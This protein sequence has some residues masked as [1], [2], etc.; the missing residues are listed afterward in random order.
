MD[1]YNLVLTDV[2]PIDRR[3]SGNSLRLF[4]RQRFFDSF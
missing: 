1:Y 3:D 4:Y 2:V